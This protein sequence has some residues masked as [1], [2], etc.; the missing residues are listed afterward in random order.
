ME[1]LKTCKTIN[2]DCKR[3]DKTKNVQ[4]KIR[5]QSWTYKRKLRIGNKKMKGRTINK[6][7]CTHK[8]L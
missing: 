8:D 5:R 7:T 1:I 2:N 3:K 4:T 6:R